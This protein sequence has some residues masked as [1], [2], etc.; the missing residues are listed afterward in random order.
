MLIVPH[1]SGNPYSSTRPAA[2][3]G[4]FSEAGKASPT[5]DA[6]VCRTAT[7]VENLRDFQE[8]LRLCFE[9]A[10]PVILLFLVLGVVM[11]LQMT[12]Y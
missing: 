7:P 5:A 1:G 8:F 3:P 9:S 2:S 12:I 10:V 11:F 6:V 4:G